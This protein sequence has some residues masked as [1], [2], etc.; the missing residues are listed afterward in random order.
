MSADIPQRIK[1]TVD[2]RQHDTLAIDCDKFH[3]ARCQV[4][5]AADGNETF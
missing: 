2:I 3:L 5:G 4:A 1:G